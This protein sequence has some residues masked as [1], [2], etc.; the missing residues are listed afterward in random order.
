MQVGRGGFWGPGWVLDFGWVLPWV[1]EMPGVVG[2]SIAVQSR[3]VLVGSNPQF[4][5]R[6]YLQWLLY[7]TWWL[8]VAT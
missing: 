7:G 3:K 5:V 4:L 6:G 1:C 8:A 2:L